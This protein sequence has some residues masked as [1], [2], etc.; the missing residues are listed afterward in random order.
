MNYLINDGNIDRTTR[1]KRVGSRN[2]AIKLIPDDNENKKVPNEFDYSIIHNIY[3]IV[4]LF[5]RIFVHMES[6]ISSFLW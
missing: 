3:S 2:D 6:S 1:D 5:Y 4:Y